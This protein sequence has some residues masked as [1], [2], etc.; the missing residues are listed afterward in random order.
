MLD[1]ALPSGP[2]T[3]S[4]PFGDQ[5][6]EIIDFLDL[7]DDINIEQDISPDE[8]RQAIILFSVTNVMLAGKGKRRVGNEDKIDVLAA[9]TLYYGLQDRSLASRLVLT[10]GFW[11]AQVPELGQSI[12]NVLKDL[13]DRL[14]QLNDDALFLER[15]AKR[16]FNLGGNNDVVGNTEF[17]RLFR[18]FVEISNDPLLSLNIDAEDK[19]PLSDKTSVGRALDLLVELK[20]VILQLVRSLSKYGTIATSRANKEWADFERRA[21]LVLKLIAEKYRASEDI[22]DKHPYAV[23][24]DLTDKQRDSE[25]APHMVLAREGQ[26]MLQLAFETYDDTKDS[27]ELVDKAHLINLFQ[28]G[29]PAKFRTE[30]MRKL[31]A[32]V[33]KYPL[34]AWS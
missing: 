12:D 27:L 2:I 24:A 1:N 23:L 19:N 28:K 29:D 17:P 18:R 11:T 26:Q 9:L 8:A 20:G 3:S 14:N 31:A 4:G 6:Q 34:Q 33:R 30:A 7:L 32:V 5:P 13:R 22:D 25:I 15:E 16:Q 21:L 10:Q